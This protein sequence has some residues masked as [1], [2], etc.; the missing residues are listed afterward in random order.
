MRHVAE[1]HSCIL[2]GGNRKKSARCMRLC[3]LRGLC[4]AQRSGVAS[5]VVQSPKIASH[6][7]DL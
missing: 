6:L 7:G 4:R 2:E 1:R 5:R 3:V